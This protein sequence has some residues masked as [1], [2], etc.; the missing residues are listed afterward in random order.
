MYLQTSF[1]HHLETDHSELPVQIEPKCNLSFVI[2]QL[3]SVLLFGIPGTP[4]PCIY[5]LVYE[6]IVFFTIYLL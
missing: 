5:R 6:D 3:I 2:K 1:S 4:D